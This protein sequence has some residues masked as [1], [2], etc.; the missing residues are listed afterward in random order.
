MLVVGAEFSPLQIGDFLK[1]LGSYK[2][3]MLGWVHD[4]TGL[5]GF[6]IPWDIVQFRQDDFHEL[7]DARLRDDRLLQ[8]EEDQT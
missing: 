7:L 6:L 4:L 2:Q 1:S 5:Q 3:R 8:D